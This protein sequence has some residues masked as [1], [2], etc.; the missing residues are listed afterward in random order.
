MTTLIMK[1]PPSPTEIFDQEPFQE[2]EVD[3]YDEPP[4]V[5]T[6]ERSPKLKKKRGRPRIHPPNLF[7]SSSSSPSKQKE[8]RSRLEPC[9]ACGLEFSCKWER[10][11][12]IYTHRRPRTLNLKNSETN[13]VLCPNC[14]DR[15]TW[16]RGGDQQ[17]DLHNYIFHLDVLFASSKLPNIPPS[18]FNDYCKHL[19]HS[20]GYHSKIQGPNGSIS[21]TCQQCPMRC[22]CSFKSFASL[23][24]HL[25]QKHKEV[26]CG[27]LEELQRDICPDKLKEVLCPPLRDDTKCQDC[28]ATFSKYTSLKR[29]LRESCKFRR[30]KSIKSHKACKCQECGMRFGSQV[31]FYRHRRKV[32]PNSIK[33]AIMLK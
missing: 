32:H 26:L 28:G 33:P 31:Y 16:V 17:L 22:R 30:D 21:Y 4:P 2:A 1:P 9:P 25:I 3:A 18:H 5:L 20:Q 8:K 13:R 6:E 14:Q 29:H 11:D 15:V 7:R 24:S 10:A 23:R 27:K 19:L 12:H